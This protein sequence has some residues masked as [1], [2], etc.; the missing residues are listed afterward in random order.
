MLHVRQKVKQHHA[1][2]TTYTKT[3]QTPLKQIDSPSY[4]IFFKVNSFVVFTVIVDKSYPLKLANGFIDALITPFF[5][6][7]KILLGAANFKSRLEG[8]T[9][10]H[11][12]V[13]FDRTI[14]QK[15]KD[16]EDPTSMKNVDRM[17]R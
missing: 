11:Y 6:E 3:E 8:I 5:D 15:K 2:V 9:S 12:F 10:D 17:K 14:K 4:G 16:F 1:E 7:A 13:K